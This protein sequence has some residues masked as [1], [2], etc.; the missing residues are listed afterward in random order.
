[1][2]L[3]RISVQG[4]RAFGLETQWL[5]LS[6]SLTIVYAGNSQGKTSLA[7]ALE[8][9]FTGTISRRDFIGSAAKEFADCLSNVHLPIG[10]PVEVGA[11][12]TDTTGK[13]HIVERRLM[14]DMTPTKDCQSKLSLNGQQ[15]PSLDGLISLSEPPLRTPILL[16]HSLR[17][18]LSA[19]PQDR[20]TYFKALL[21]IADLD[22]LQAEV[23]AAT[24]RFESEPPVMILRL[25]QVMQQGGFTIPTDAQDPDALRTSLLIALRDTLDLTGVALQDI[26]AAARAKIDSELQALFPFH[27]VAVGSL[28]IPKPTFD[29]TGDIEVASQLLRASASINEEM[30]RFYIAALAL[31]GLRETADPID[32]PLCET[33]HALTPKR[34]QALRAHVASG[35]EVRR[36]ST[37]LT[38]A[39][40]ELLTQLSATENSIK[41]ASPGF[42]SWSAAERSKSGIDQAALAL[43]MDDASA[44]RVRHWL[45]LAE[46]ADSAR[47]HALAEIDKTKRAVA[48]VDNHNPSHASLADVER[49]VFAV[50][51]ALD[52]FTSSHD[53]LR[54]AFQ[55]VESLL[56]ERISGL[57]NLSLP[58]ELISLLPH[59]SDL[60]T[61]LLEAT[62]RA[63]MVSALRQA[64]EDIGVASR[65]LLDIRF[66]EVS[67]EISAWW[68]R[69]RPE[70]L[71]SFAGLHRAGSGK[72]FLDLKAALQTTAVDPEKKLRDAVAVFSDSQLNCLGLSAFLAR[73]TRENSPFVI[74]DDPIQA[75]DEEHRWTFVSRVPEAI[76]GAGRQLLILTHDQRLARDL[77]DRYEHLNPAYFQLVLDA[78]ADGG[79]VR[80]IRDSLEVQLNRADTLKNVN[81]V[82]TRKR[83]A[84]IL[85]DATERFCKRVMVTRRRQAADD[86]ALLSDYEGQV[87]GILIPAVTPYLTVDAS[88]PGK[89]KM[90]AHNLNPGSHDDGVPPSAAIKHCLGDL[91]ALVKGYLP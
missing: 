51:A 64:N 24:E 14:K 26:E 62:A 21:D 88:H 66:D 63:A 13:N 80:L 75:S 87:L 48:L 83:A 45:D 81:D 68:T 20:T 37:V 27:D 43:L 33:N 89:L 71:S 47:S 61:L 72:R 54:V 5:D 31:P 57:K 67:S 70:E 18:L 40:A 73:I 77:Q 90:I 84:H 3:D 56:R 44:D 30:E 38:T 22:R 86:R 29:A 39:L 6:P 59:T 11:V 8:F 19:K 17:Y 25:N 65:K 41:A 12:V 69:M 28:D 58:R 55:P 32:C 9:L 82:E 1:M 52:V 76:V 50:L 2:R 35:A 36:A 15:V 7:E 49:S 4:F 46:V 23:N 10:A 78:P 60:T 85:R 79:R 91:K 74:L 34:L 16:Q 42:L 53:N